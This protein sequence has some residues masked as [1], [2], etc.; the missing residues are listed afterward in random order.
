LGELTLAAAARTALE[1]SFVSLRFTN[2]VKRELW[3]TLPFPLPQ[4]DLPTMALWAYCHEDDVIEAHVRSVT[5]PEAAYPGTH[6]P[7]LLAAPDTRFDHPTRPLLAQLGRAAPPPP[8]FFHGPFEGNASVFDASKAAKRLG[9][10]FQ[11]WQDK[12]LL[13]LQGSR[14]SRSA[15]ADPELRFFYLDGFTLES[16][17]TLPKG[18]SLAYKI[19]GDLKKP[20]VLHT[21]SFDAVHTELEYNIGPGKTLD[22]DKYTVVVVNMFGNGASFS[23]SLEKEAAGTQAPLVTTIGDNV[24]RVRVTTTSYFSTFH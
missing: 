9:I 12:P 17:E 4:N 16:G 5:M 3:G 2:I 22:T 19:H 14:A 7:Y 23:P 11:S 24:N 20:V 18:A 6:E 10:T 21:T 1:T 13:P 15:L 8:E